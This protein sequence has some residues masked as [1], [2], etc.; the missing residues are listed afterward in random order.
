MPSEKTSALRT[1]LYRSTANPG[2]PSARRESIDTRCRLIQLQTVCSQGDG[3]IDQ[4][5]QIGFVG[6]LT[7]P[8]K[9]P[10]S[11]LGSIV[12][13]SIG[14]QLWSIGIV[15]RVHTDPITGLWSTFDSEN[16][17]FEDGRVEQG[18][19]KNTEATGSLVPRT[20]GRSTCQFGMRVIVPH[21]SAQIAE[22]RTTHCAW[23]NSI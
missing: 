19:D 14:E 2:K 17:L 8:T 18:R 12:E 15:D 23:T 21:Q 10:Y 11:D 20:N 16:P 7:P 6:K 13:D 3:S 22:N 4:L 9:E 5:I 1:S